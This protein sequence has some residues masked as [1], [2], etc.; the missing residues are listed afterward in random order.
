[1][2]ELLQGDPEVSAHIREDVLAASFDLDYHFAQV[3]R[4]F[5]RVFGGIG[6]RAC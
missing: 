6:I 4:I 3:D 1:M 5:A 2:L